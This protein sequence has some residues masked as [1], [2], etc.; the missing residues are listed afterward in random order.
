[1]ADRILLVKVT[2]FPK[3]QGSHGSIFTMSLRNTSI[4]HG[5][6]SPLPA[7]SVLKKQTDGMEKGNQSGGGYGREEKESGMRVLRGVEP[8]THAG[9]GG[10]CHG[11]PSLPSMSQ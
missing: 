9:S 6:E 5:S 7:S 4:S 8:L 11:N 2:H 1:M 10:S 3:S